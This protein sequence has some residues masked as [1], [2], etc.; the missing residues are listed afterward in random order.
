MVEDIGDTPTAERRATV[1]DAHILWV[2]TSQ[3]T[4]IGI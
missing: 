1:L 4:S 3:N 2:G